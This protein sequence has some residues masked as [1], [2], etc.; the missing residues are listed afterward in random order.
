VKFAYPAL[1]WTLLALFAA[2]T[3]AWVV[4][5]RT[6]P[7]WDDAWYLAGSLRMYDAL[8]EGGVTSYVRE[9]FRVLGNKAPLITTLPAPVYLLFG[10]HARYGVLI[11]LPAMLLLFA[12]VRA[13]AARLAGDR[14][15]ALAV[16][17]VGTAP[18]LYGLSRMFLV[19]YWLAALV[20][21][22]MW[23]LLTSGTLSRSWAVVAFG[24]LCGFG[25]LLKISYP[26]YIAGPLLRSLWQSRS[27]GAVL[28]Q[29]ITPVL[30]LAGPWYL[31]HAREAVERAWSSGFGAAARDYSLSY[32]AYLS[33]IGHATLSEFWAVIALALLAWLL[34]RR[35]PLPGGILLGCWAAPALLFLLAPN[36]DVRFLA[37]LVPAFAVALAV[38]ID[39]AFPHRSMWPWILAAGPI[40]SMFIVSFGWP[41]GRFEVGYA[42]S[43]NRTSWPLAEIAKIAAQ[44]TLVTASDLAALNADNLQLAARELRLPL[45]VTTTAYESDPEAV[46][47]LIRSVSAVVY[48]DGGASEVPFT[49]RWREIAL[50]ELRTASWVERSAIELPDGGRAR[51]F[52]N[53]SL[54]PSGLR[55]VSR[56]FYEAARPEPIAFDAEFGEQIRLEGLAVE[57]ASHALRVVYA[58]RCLGQPSRDYWAFTHVLDSNGGVIGYLDHKILGGFSTTS[59]WRPGDTASEALELPSSAIQPGN[60]YYLRLGVYHPESGDRLDVSRLAPLN[61]W[62]VSLA[63]HSTAVI[64]A[65]K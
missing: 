30:V 6:P 18:L 10:R 20:A 15:A 36:K 61:A 51:I 5:D 54:G 11:N 62:D 48:K 32:R 14:A 29:I 1:F 65:A 63:D 21:L 43:F 13:I 16:I 2:A 7:T 37:P 17:V 47:A 8:T 49:N 55:Y 34:W 3:L 19:E 4:L 45:A 26:V 31:V 44:G 35:I 60:V 22:A 53:H 57:A 33:G 12:A 28:T 25:L 64:V 27:R 38:A 50:A 9:F 40:A 42:R 56:G 24:A 52:L 59:T 39:R 58:W 23:L 41:V 46:R